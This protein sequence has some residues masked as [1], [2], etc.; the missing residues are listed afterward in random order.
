MSADKYLY[1]GAKFI[2]LVELLRYRALHQPHQTAYT[3]LQDGEVELGSLTYQELDTQARAIAAYIQSRNAQGQRALLL[4]PPGLEFISAFFGCLYSG[5]VAVPAY[6]PRPHQKMSL[7]KSIICDSQSSIALTSNSMLVDIQNWLNEERES[8]AIHLLATDNI[9]NDLATTWQ[10]PEINSNTLA[11][12]QYTSA[13]TSNPKGVMV[14]HGNL[15]KTLKDLNVAWQHTPESVMVSWLSTFHD[16]GLIHGVLEP[17]HFGF[18]CYL[19]PPASFVQKPLRWLEAIS[20]YGATHSAAP[21]FAYDLCVSKITEEQK[22]NLDLSTWK[23]AFNAAEPTSYATVEQFIKAFAV[24]GFRAD[25]LCSKYGLAETTIKVSQVDCDQ[26]TVLFH[27][28]TQ[29]LEQHHLVKVPSDSDNCQTWVD[30]NEVALDTEIVIAD[31]ERLNRC[32]PDEVGEIWVTGSCVAQGDISRVSSQVLPQENNHNQMILKIKSASDKR[33]NNSDHPCHQSRQQE[34]T[35]QNRQEELEK[36]VRE[37]IIELVKVNEALQTKIAKLKRAEKLARRQTQTLYQTLSA[38]IAEPQLDK[39]LDKVL[40]AI[41]EQLAVSSCVIWLNDLKSETRFLHTLY[42][43]GQILTGTQLLEHPNALKLRTLG[44]HPIWLREFSAN[45]PVIIN[46]IANSSYLEPQQREYA[47]AL[48]VKGLLEVPLIVDDKAIGYLA[49]YNTERERFSAIEVELAQA[50]THQVILALQL[51]RTAEKA[52]Q[53]LEQ[54]AVLKERNRI[55][56]E[57]HNSLKHLQQ[58]LIP[59][60]AYPFDDALNMAKVNCAKMQNNLLQNKPTEESTEK[61]RSIYQEYAQFELGMQE[62]VIA[63]KMPT[64]EHKKLE[65]PPSGLLELTQ[66]ER[67]VLRMIASGANNREIAMALCLSEGTVRNHISHIL[68]RLNVRDR[69]QAALIANTYPSFFMNEVVHSPSI[70]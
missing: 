66:R 70:D 40:I 5:V 13:S 49:V 58:V 22:A 45:H 69:T 65:K 29:D 21:N 48:G 27:V 51:T 44:Q 47:K 57:L 18:P 8:A 20:R 37:R 53:E 4:Y 56:R 24:C 39:L 17:L 38:L 68:S 30:C 55:V 52:K 36:K 63:K 26:P 50:L 60:N 19:M 7:L 59:D 54:S 14:S 10:Q 2:T 28:S 43:H 34:H 23:M 15:L 35:P 1:G 64:T 16:L 11:F 41:A 42:S 31:P 3:F 62:A 46:D 32:A 67:E 61:V 33:I 25:T 9:A 6:L 12:L